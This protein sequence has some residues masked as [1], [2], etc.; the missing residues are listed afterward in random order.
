MIQYAL[1]CDDFDFSACSNRQLYSAAKRAY[2]DILAE[3]MEIA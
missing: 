1:E 2:R 3:S